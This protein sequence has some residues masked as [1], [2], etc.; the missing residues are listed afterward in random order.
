MPYVTAAA[1]A[2]TMIWRSAHLKTPLRVNQPMTPPTTPALS[3]A[4]PI[5]HTTGSPLVVT[6]HGNN[7][8]SAPRQ[9][10]MSEE[11]AAPQGDPVVEGSTPNS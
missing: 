11:I 8:M 5:D 7:G 3:T 10:K 9:Q 1:K 4:S 2:P 6:I